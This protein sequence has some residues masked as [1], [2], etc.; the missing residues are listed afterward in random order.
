M[1]KRR[2]YRHSQRARAQ[3]MAGPQE[4]VYETAVPRSMPD[5][6]DRAV[7]HGIEM[8]RGRILAEVRREALVAAHSEPY[9]VMARRGGFDEGFNAGMQA[10]QR[11]EAPKAAQFTYTDVESARRRGY[12]EGKAASTGIPNVD[13]VSVRRKMLD[14]M[15]QDC[16]V[17][18][19]SNPSM[20]PG[21]NA[22]RHLIKKRA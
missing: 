18:A 22:V 16:R 14:G 12:A 1:R 13:E 10:A 6:F 21:V 15:L 2:L 3:Q 20:A 4:H 8:A 17:I 9:L 7:Q 11:A 19:E 5:E